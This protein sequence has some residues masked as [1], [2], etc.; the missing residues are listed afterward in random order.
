MIGKELHDKLKIINY[1][2][3]KID[4]VIFHNNCPDGFGSAW[5]VWRHLKGD[6]TY[7]G[8]TPDKLPVYTSLKNKY[9]LF[10]DVSGSK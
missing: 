1:D 6:A 4:Y 9:V 7:L 2:L 10:V 8:I 5:I 3:D